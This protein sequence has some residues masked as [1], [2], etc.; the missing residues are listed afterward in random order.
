[1]LRSF[2]PRGVSTDVAA[3]DEMYRFC[4]G[5]AGGWRERALVHYFRSGLS[6]IATIAQVLRWHA[7]RGGPEPRILDFAS[8]FGRVTRFLVTMVPADRVWV[9]DVQ[10]AGVEFQR[11][12]LGVHGIVSG[13][14][15]SAFDVD[16]T[17]DAILCL[18]LFSHLPERV[19]SAWLG[20]LWSLLSETGC[21]VFSTLG[22]AALPDGV[23]LSAEGVHYTDRSE[24]AAVPKSHY[25]TTWA[26]EDFVAR[27]IESGCPGA[28]WLR[29][30]KALWHLQ[31]L[32]VVSRGE[33]LDALAVERG[34]EGH[35]ENALLDEPDRLHLGGWVVDHD[36]PTRAPRVEVRLGQGPIQSVGPDHAREDVDRALH[37]P[38]RRAGGW[39]LIYEAGGALRS[40]DVL[41]I[42]ARGARSSFLLHSGTLEGSLLA[43]CLAR[44]SE[45][46]AAR[47]R[48]LGELSVTLAR[49]QASS[50]SLHERLCW[51]ERSRF[52]RARNRWWAL[53]R[54][55]GKPG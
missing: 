47:E 9:A 22:E 33:D 54:A 20:K 32:W 3:G 28:R 23:R 40:T 41:Q 48:Q 55:L 27:R 31:D 16:R 42:W 53:K 45:A 38:S 26:S 4:I 6:A 18:S 17:F 43:H 11:Q 36:D 29:F 25:G 24:S 49:E 15:P 46:L 7:G 34:P 10:G 8:G 13:L 19:F 39:S 44:T 21:L 30:P 2:V 35:L 14:E 52:W 51:M 1:V 37:L 5:Q 50:R 12:H